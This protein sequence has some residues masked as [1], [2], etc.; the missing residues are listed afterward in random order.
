[1]LSQPNRTGLFLKP[2]YAWTN[3]FTRPPNFKLWSRL[4]TE[5]FYKSCMI[6]QNIISAKRSSTTNYAAAI[7]FQCGRTGVIW[8]QTRWI[9]YVGFESS[10]NFEKYSSA[11]RRAA[12]SWH[13]S[14]E[15]MV[16][17]YIKKTSKTTPGQ[18]F[19]ERYA[20]SK[21]NLVHRKPSNLFMYIVHLC[22][23]KRPDTFYT[24]LHVCTYSYNIV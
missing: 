15:Q 1:M 24:R 7:Y 18:S 11:F 9:G 19:S 20:G 5:I 10:N 22:I 23:V 3:F 13:W 4:T 12:N 2:I 8:F 16:F 14:L 6:T 17:K 21:S